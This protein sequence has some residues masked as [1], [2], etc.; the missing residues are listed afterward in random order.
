MPEAYMQKISSLILGTAAAVGVLS[1]SPLAVA[2]QYMTNGQ[3]YQVELNKTQILRLPASAGAIVIGNPSIADVSVHAADTLFVVGRGYGET[4]L[5][6]LDRQGQTLMDTNIQVSQS[7]SSQSVRVFNRGNRQSYNCTPSCQPAPVLGDSPDFIGDFTSS[8]RRIISSE[9]L[10]AQG[11]GNQGF[12]GAGGG[13][14]AEQTG[15]GPIG[16]GPASQGTEF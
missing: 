9:A 15:P 4:N 2:G 5:I 1:L 14:N 3:A 12:P 11:I 7:V 6:I 8:E 13:F 16:S 10:G